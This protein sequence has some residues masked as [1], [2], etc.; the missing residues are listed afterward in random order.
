MPKT[1]TR[2]GRGRGR[3]R[4]RARGVTIGRGA[5]RAHRLGR[6]SSA[7]AKAIAQSRPRCVGVLKHTPDPDRLKGL[8]TAVS[9]Q[10]L[11]EY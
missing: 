8:F 11:F 9:R 2:R 5:Y 4:G 7:V 3:G 1:P 10:L 6:G